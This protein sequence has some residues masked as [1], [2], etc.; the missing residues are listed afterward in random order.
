MRNGCIYGLPT[1]ALPT[2]A[3]ASSSWPTT[4]VSRGGYSRD[5]GDPGKERPPLEGASQAWPTPNAQE[6][7]AGESLQARRQKYADKYGN[8][9]FGLT[10][11][12]SVQSWPTPRAEDSESAGNHPKA[13]DSLTGATKQW[14]TP[15]AS[16][17]QGEMH[18]S[19]AAKAKGYAPRL[20][21]QARASQ[22]ATPNVPDRGP[23]TRASKAKRGAGGEDLQTQTQQWPTPNCPAPH[24]SEQTAGAGRQPREGCGKMLQDVA[25]RDWMTPQ[26]RD[27]KSGESPSST[28]ELYGTTGP[29]LSHQ[30]LRTPMPGEPSSSSAPTSRPRLNPA[31]V[32]WLMGWPWFWTRAEPTSF[33]ARETESWRTRLQL[34]LCCLLGEP[35]WL[36]EPSTWV[37]VKG[38]L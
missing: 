16:D 3:I 20:Q 33:A 34:H 8:N 26:A 29:P 28:E 9:G 36:S 11:N 25:T 24:D 1:S 6:Y 31:F 23:E 4:R 35:A 10:L 14:A 7:G 32:C 15:M 22:W 2:S 12:Q 38:G 27:Y 30:V 17:A 18:Q 13:T 37:S 19:E 21:D 5:H